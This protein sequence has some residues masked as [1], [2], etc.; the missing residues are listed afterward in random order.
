MVGI[1]KFH[2]AFQ[3]NQIYRRDSPFDCSRGANIHKSRRLHRPMNGFKLPAPGMSLLF[4]QLIQYN[5]PFLNR[6]HRV[7]MHF[8]TQKQSATA[9]P[10]RPAWFSFVIDAVDIILY[11]SF[12]S[13]W[14]CR[15]FPCAPDKQIENHSRCLRNSSIPSPV[16]LLMWTIEPTP[17]SFRNVSARS[18]SAGFLH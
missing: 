5:S 6:H 1:T 16:T 7:P 17:A 9:T 18:T 3:V 13:Q 4:Q 15:F 10:P 8:H 12:P 2:L 14:L 11:A